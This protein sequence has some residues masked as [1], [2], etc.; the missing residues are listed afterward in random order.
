M[1]TNLI[2]LLFPLYLLFQIDTDGGLIFHIYMVFLANALYMFNSIILSHIIY[3]LQ[4]WCFILPFL[5]DSK[6]HEIA[7]FAFACCILSEILFT[8]IWGCNNNHARNNKFLYTLHG[9]MLGAYTLLPSLKGNYYGTILHSIAI[10]LRNRKARSEIIT[11][12]EISHLSYL[13]LYYLG[14]KN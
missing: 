6:N 9:A 4:H 7:T 5:T 8:S 11:F 3:I 14:C 1:I 10:A 13:Y 2:Q 12:F